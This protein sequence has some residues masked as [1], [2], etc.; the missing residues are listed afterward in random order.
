V[1]AAHW[2]KRTSRRKSLV[3]KSLVIKSLVIKSLVIKSLGIK[4]LVIAPLSAARRLSMASKH[5]KIEQ[6]RNIRAE[7]VR[8]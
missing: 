8:K 3:I 7:Q 5:P 4:S 1:W 2:R 6:Q